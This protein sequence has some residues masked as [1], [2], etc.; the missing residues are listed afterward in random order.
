MS[1]SYIRGISYDV[2]TLYSLFQEYM[3]KSRKEHE[4]YY[5]VILYDDETGYIGDRLDQ[6][7]D[8]LIEFNNIEEAIRMMKEKINEISSNS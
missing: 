8:N 6:M 1:H 7:D 5:C 2:N 4:K 3:I